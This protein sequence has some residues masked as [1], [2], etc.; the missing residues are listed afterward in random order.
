MLPRV[1]PARLEEYLVH[2]HAH[3]HSLT[4]NPL[5]SRQHHSEK[6]QGTSKTAK[7]K[8]TPYCLPLGNFSHTNTHTHIYTHTC[9]QTHTRARSDTPRHNMRHAQ[10]LLFIWLF[11]SC[12][13]WLLG[14]RLPLVVYGLQEALDSAALHRSCQEGSLKYGRAPPGRDNRNLEIVFRSMKRSF[15]DSSPSCPCRFAH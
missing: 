7:Q 13:L 5:N 6:K 10:T 3:A 2:I 8:P 15:R 11:F 12:R 14:R 4:Q 9:A 1:L